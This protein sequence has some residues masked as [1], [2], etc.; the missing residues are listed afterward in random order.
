[1]SLIQ[2][3][4]TLGPFGLSLMRN[5]LS[6]LDVPMK[7]AI[8]RTHFNVTVP[9][10]IVVLGSSETTRSTK[11]GGDAGLRAMSG[12]LGDLDQHG[13][14]VEVLGREHGGHSE[15]AEQ[16]S[17]RRRDDPACDDRHVVSG[18]AKSL[19]DPWDQLHM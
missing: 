19:Y 12:Q 10:G 9:G 8:L 14:Q 1:M 11:P 7:E 2:S 13:G 5:V 16:G 6:Y 15:L 17:V 4:G 3:W 18:G